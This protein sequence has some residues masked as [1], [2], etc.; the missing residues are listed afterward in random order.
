MDTIVNANAL[1]FKRMIERVI[2]HN[3]ELPGDVTII[4][5][6][7][8]QKAYLDAGVGVYYGNSKIIFLAH[9]EKNNHE[10]MYLELEN[11]PD[12]WRLNYRIYE[13]I[14]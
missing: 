2:I 9:W 13:K 8:D 7:K 10:I 5:E 3:I 12:N 4:K 6:E 14:K 11:P 1:A